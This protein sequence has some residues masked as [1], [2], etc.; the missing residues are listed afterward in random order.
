MM[1]SIR[2]RLFA[3]L[4]AATGAVWLLAVLWTYLSTQQEV[5]RVLD[6]RLTEAARMVSSLITDHHIDVAAAVD[7]ARGSD[8]AANFGTAAGD[9]NRQLSCQIWSLQGDLVS[10]SESAPTASLSEHDVGFAEQVV[11]G[12]RWRVYAVVN[13]ELGV[14]VLV[15]DSIEI[16]DGLVG[17]VIKGQ[18]VPALAILPILA[19]LIWLSV[20][21]GLSPLS[22]IAE[23]LSSRSADELHALND[24]GA[25]REVRPLLQSLNALFQR[26]RDARDREKTFIAYAAHELK[27]PLAGLKTQA[28]VALR[29]DSDDVRD[30]ALLQISTSVDRTSRLVRQLIDLAAVDSA[31]GP[32]APEMLDM[33]A[34]VEDLVGEM[35]ALRTAR[36]ITVSAEID[37]DIPIQVASKALLRLALRNILENAIQYAPHGSS[38]RI[39]GSIRNGI[40]R[41]DVIDQGSGIEEKDQLR[42]MARFQRG[43]SANTLGSGLGLSIVEMAVSKLGGRLSFL[44]KDGFCVR[45]EIPPS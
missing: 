18:L 2:L 39:A 14:R 28:Q 9:Y 12:E 21:R 33:K 23:T 42:V 17:D 13:P 1:R 25:P 37:S 27:T 36:E 11:N 6:A 8:L 32:S 26:V 29:S 45:L 7:A 35:A 10:R 16:R 24:S 15:G 30:R 4:L 34:M 22:A 31:E 43:T 38:V 3:I 5:E 40:T 19:G 41:I 20:G 44:R